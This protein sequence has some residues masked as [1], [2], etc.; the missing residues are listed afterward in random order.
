MGNKEEVWF[1]YCIPS[2]HLFGKSTAKSWHPAPCPAVGPQHLR[3]VCPSEASP[4]S[5]LASFWVSARRTEP[6]GGFL[7]RLRRFL[8]DLSAGV[9]QPD[10][11][12]PS[13]GARSGES[14]GWRLVEVLSRA[15]LEAAVYMDGGFGGGFLMFRKGDAEP[16]ESSW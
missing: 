4:L 1:N 15:L 3:A 13:C 5:F 8:C 11:A 16:W 2:S 9:T 14:R 10:S 6:G 12:S 7:C